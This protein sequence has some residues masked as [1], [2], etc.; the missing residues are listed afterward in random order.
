M[1]PVWQVTTISQKEF[2]PVIANA[3]SYYFIASN[4]YKFYPYL[5]IHQQYR[6]R[7]GRV[8][9]RNILQCFLKQ[10]FLFMLSTV[11]WLLYNSSHLHNT[12]YKFFNLILRQ[13]LLALTGVYQVNKTLHSQSN[14]EYF[15]SQ[16]PPC[17]WLLRR[18]E[19]LLSKD[20]F[21]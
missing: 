8:F 13:C 6:D 19:S 15:L 17:E 7:P 1:R 9:H 5:D 4:N 3:E 21:S 14:Q 2:Q 10:I 16:H 11:T 20:H 12:C 18:Q